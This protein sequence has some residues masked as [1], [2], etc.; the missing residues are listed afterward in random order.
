LNGIAI[1]ISDWADL[2]HWRLRTDLPLEIDDLM[3]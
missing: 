2:P 3:T 1:A